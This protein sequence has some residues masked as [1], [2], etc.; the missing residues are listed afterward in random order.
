LNMSTAQ[1]DADP[2]S[3][4]A[5][6]VRDDVSP[7]EA[8]D[9]LEDSLGKGLLRRLDDASEGV[10]EKAAKLLLALLQKGPGAAMAMLP[11]A[12]PVIE[13]RLQ[14]KQV[15]VCVCVC[16]CMCVCACVCVC[17]GVT[18]RKVNTCVDA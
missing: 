17:M 4:Q 10:R 15:C 5:S 14:M 16:V 1:R 12:M 18:S 6:L 8:A 2:S 9:L 7:S 11:Y 3:E 13:E